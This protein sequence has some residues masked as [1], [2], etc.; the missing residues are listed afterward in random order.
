M[1]ELYNQKCLFRQIYLSNLINRFTNASLSVEGV[2]RSLSDPY[3]AMQIYYQSKALEYVF[4]LPQNEQLTLGNIKEIEKIITNEELQNFR[5]TQAEVYGSSIPRTKPQN[6]YMS[7]YQLFDNYYNIWCDLDPFYKEA[8]FHIRF[9]HI[10]PFED[11]NGRTAR[12]LLIRNLCANNQ[13][14]CVITKE[15]KSEYC[16][17]IE[18]ND[19]EGLANFLRR[20]SEKEL[21]IMLNIYNDLNQKGLIESNNMTEAQQIEYQNCKV[22]KK[23]TK[24]NQ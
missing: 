15:T 8:L 13:I 2:E 17:Y 9:L 6:I 19:P 7:L 1:I 21:E 3:Q 23:D 14:P 4:D 16:Q 11:G 5:T 22:L 12:I 24:N 10:H 18:N 20:L